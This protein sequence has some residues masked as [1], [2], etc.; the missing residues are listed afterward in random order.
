M[1]AEVCPKYADNL[2][3]ILKQGFPNWGLRPRK[4]SNIT[5]STAYTL[6]KIGILYAPEDR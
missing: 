5:Q 3:N 2:T 1:L 6:C 4:G